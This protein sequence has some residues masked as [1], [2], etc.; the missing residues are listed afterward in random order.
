MLNFL[1]LAVLKINLNLKNYFLVKVKNH[2]FLNFRLNS[3]SYTQIGKDD[4]RKPDSV[5]RSG[6]EGP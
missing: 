3:C 6:F 5:N 1:D 4:K 2:N